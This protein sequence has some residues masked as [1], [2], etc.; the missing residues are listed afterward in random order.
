MV[1]QNGMF[2]RRALPQI[3]WQNDHWI[4]CDGIRTGNRQF[5]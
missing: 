1:L 2:F 4:K 5:R 3:D